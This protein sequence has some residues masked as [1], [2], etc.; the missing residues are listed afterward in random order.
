MST[1]VR[2]GWFA[3]ALA[4]AMAL[5]GL[6]GTAAAQAEITDERARQIALERVPGTVVSVERETDN[7]VRVVEVEIR[8]QQNDVI[9][10]DI[11]AR[12]GRILEVEEE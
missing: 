7:G 9:E 1:K 12:S 2:M 6:A 8:N 11:D 3:G 5:A 4:G 10:V